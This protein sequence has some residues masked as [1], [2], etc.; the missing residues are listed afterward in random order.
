MQQLNAQEVEMVNGG[1][2]VIAAVGLFIV[3][4]LATDAMGWTNVWPD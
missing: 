1:A 3:V 2:A 4:T